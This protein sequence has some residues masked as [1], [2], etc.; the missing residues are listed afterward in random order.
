LKEE[1]HILTYN[2]FMDIPFDAPGSWMI[3]GRTNKIVYELKEEAKKHGLYFKDTSEHKSFDLNKYRAVLS[4]DKL[5][6]GESV[7]KEDVQ[8]IYTYINDIQ[9]GYRSTDTKKWSSVDKEQLLD[10][11]FLQEQGGLNAKIKNWQDM[12]NRN[13]PEKDKIYFENVIKN[14]TN[15]DEDPRILIDTIHSIKGDE[16]DHIVLYEKSSF[17][18]SIYRKSSKEVS[19]EYRVWYVGVTR[20]KKYLH[21]LRSSF[22]TTFPLCRLKNELERIDYE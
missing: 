8:V 1:G 16:A 12:F 5:L 9:H 11:K 3:L 15:M 19:S 10:L 22:D 21:I 17:A 2:R 14:G 20:A 7:L 6:N 4:W 13:F 18:A